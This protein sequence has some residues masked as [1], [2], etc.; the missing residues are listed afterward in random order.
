VRSIWDDPGVSVHRTTLI[1]S[2]LIP[3]EPTTADLIAT[4]STS[5]T[6][7]KT[8]WKRLTRVHFSDQRTHL[9]R[10]TLGRIMES[11]RQKRL[12]LS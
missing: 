1:I 3:P 7:L 5:R 9:S 12:R 8:G 6:Y 11:Q 2:G 4:S 10:D